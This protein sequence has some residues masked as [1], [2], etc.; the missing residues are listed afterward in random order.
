M[1][2]FFLLCLATW[3]L[4]PSLGYARATGGIA[5]PRP[6]LK[7]SMSVEE[8]IK[9]RRTTR[10]FEPRAITLQ[11]LSQLL[12]AAYGITAANG[13]YKSV[14]SAGALY[15][16]DIWAVVGKDG[17]QGLGAGVYRYLSQGHSLLPVKEGDAREALARAS[18]YQSWI[19]EAPVILVVTGEYER[20]ARKYGQRAFRYT[21]I[22]AGHAG[23]SI[24][25][26][27][28]AL[29]L[30]AGIVGAFKEGQ[31][32]QALGTGAVHDPILVMPVGY[33]RR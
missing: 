22:E 19:A 3:L 20:S 9:A 10:A 12:W 29:G 21:H 4:V 28:E 13:P 26:Q 31:V 6:A 27:A 11:H 30:A 33:A 7:G 15:P 32:Q 25:L 18:L 8:A 17:V 14:A 23:H 1:N 16:L 5:L 2:G 24:F